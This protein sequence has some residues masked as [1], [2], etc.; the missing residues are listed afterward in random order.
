LAKVVFNS[1][2]ILK[3]WLELKDIIKVLYLIIYWSYINHWCRLPF[4]D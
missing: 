2:E 3:V 4:K 1:E